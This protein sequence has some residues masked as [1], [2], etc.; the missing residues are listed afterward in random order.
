MTNITLNQN[1][2]RQWSTYAEIHS[3]PAVWR[4]WAP[5]LVSQID[6]IHTWLRDRNHDEVWFCGAGSSAFIGQALAFY[7]NSRSPVARFRAIATTD[8]VA[9]PRSFLHQQGKLLVVSIGRSGNSSESIGTLDALDALSPDSDRLHITCNA[10]GTLATRSV[11]G[12]GVLRTVILPEQTNDLGFAMT[13]SYTTML[14][15]A[16]ACFDTQAPLAVQDILPKLADAAESL[17]STFAD[18][19]L[20]STLVRPERAVFLGSGVLLAGARESALKVMELTAGQ[21][22][23]LWDTTLGFR[24]GPK[25]FFTTQSCAYVL[26]SSDPLTQR[27][28]LDLAQEIRKQYGDQTVVTIGSSSDCDI[29]LPTVGND[30]WSLALYVLRA[31]YLAMQWSHALGKNVD[32]PFA[33]KNLTRVVS[34]VTLYPI[35]TN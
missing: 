7:M 6:E 2:V 26:I 12:P 35:A 28:D 23:T 4:E 15:T 19:Q 17:L 14:L 3:Q 5:K 27:Y 16:L 13:L 20:K 34:G 11:P 1:D 9:Q 18:L 10:Q 33:G 22:P 8:F 32:D 31:Q 29:S 21:I 25:A 30:G 24:H